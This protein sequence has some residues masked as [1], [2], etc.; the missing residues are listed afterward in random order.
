MQDVTNNQLKVERFLQ[1][2]I[3]VYFTNFED[4]LTFCR[5]F[6]K[7]CSVIKRRFNWRLRRHKTVTSQ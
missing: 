6:K 5:R 1:A 3:L 2:I 7:F 4:T